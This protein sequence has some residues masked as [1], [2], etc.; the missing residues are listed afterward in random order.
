M[1]P[2]AK[3]R[4]YHKLSDAN[5]EIDLF[6]PDLVKEIEELNRF[7]IKSRKSIISNNIEKKYDKVMRLT[8]DEVGNS[9]LRYG[10]DADPTFTEAG[11][12]D[13][14]IYRKCIGTTLSVSKLRGLVGLK[15]DH[16]KLVEDKSKSILPKYVIE[17]LPS[18]VIDGEDRTKVLLKSFKQDMLD[19]KDGLLTLEVE[20]VKYSLKLAMR[21]VRKNLKEEIIGGK[22]LIDQDSAGK[23]LPCQLHCDGLVITSDGKIILAQRGASV[24][25]ESLVWGAS[26]GESMEWDKDRCGD[27]LLPHPICTLWRGMEEELGLDRNSVLKGGEGAAEVDFIELGFEWN[28]LIY[29]LFAIINLKNINGEEALLHAWHGSTDSEPRAYALMDF[30]IDN[31]A[32]AIV[33]GVIDGRKLNDSARFAILN[34]GLREFGNA[35]LSKMNAVGDKKYNR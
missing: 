15:Y 25:V 1:D 4:G 10:I 19:V 12:F 20:P 9:N 7:F 16:I 31:S 21:Q 6:V 26:F 32:T 11:L 33:E 2:D 22:F 18:I 17:T 27:A 14:K 24:D 28:N 13:Q 23:F 29:I 30:N 34:A 3:G 35:L 8:E 5:I